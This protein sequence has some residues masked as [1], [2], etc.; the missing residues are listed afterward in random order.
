M[1][2]VF[3]GKRDA[4]F[5]AINL[6]EPFY[7]YRSWVFKQQKVTE[8]NDDETVSTAPPPSKN[9]RCK[10]SR[11]QKATLLLRADQIDNHR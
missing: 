1:K 2:L 7:K 8:V 5:G 6:T 3:H 9:L 4:L 11:T 10:M